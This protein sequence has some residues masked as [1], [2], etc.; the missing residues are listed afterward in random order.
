M[1]RTYAR[2]VRGA[3]QIKVCGFVE[4]IRNKRTMAFIVLKD[5]TGKVQITVEKG[6]DE[7][8]DAAVNAITLDSVI[9]VVGKAVE[10]EYVKLGGVE[11]YPKQIIIESLAA[12][13]PIDREASKGHERSSIDQRIDY[14]WIDLRTEKNQMMFKVQTCMINAMRQYLLEKNFIEIHTPKLI[15]AASESGADVFEVKYFDRNA[16]LAQS[17]QFYKQMAMASGFERIFEVGPVFRAEKSFTSKHTTEFS[18]FDLEFSYI[19]SFRDVMKLEEELLTYALGKVKEAY[20]E[21]IERLFGTK[22]IV[23]TTPFP[24]IKLADLYAELEKEYGYKVPEEEKGD[25]TTEAEHLSF[26]WVQKKYGHEFLFITDYSA[27]KRAFYHMRD[28]SG[29]PQ[30]YD[31]IW[32]GVEITTGAQR[33]HRYD[34]L[35]A[36]AD[37]KGLTEDVKFYLEFFR[38]GC[39]PHGGFGLGIDRL[40]MLLLGM[41]IKEAMFIFRGPNRLNP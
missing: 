20:G 3:E 16:Y 12:P 23:P 40:T 5:I 24:V 9:T 14:R 15:G 30:G 1:E 34:Q 18:G 13:L 37:E 31:L 4:N 38:Y 11:I 8:L 27:E 10:S 22:V 17:P 7:A 41:T 32:R 33:E 25:L 39:P 36:Q 19:E 26:D 28:E 29:V 6:C 2:D 35:K 21:D